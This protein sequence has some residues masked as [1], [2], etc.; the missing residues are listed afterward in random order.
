[1]SALFV[2]ALVAICAPYLQGGAT[3]ALDF[4]GAVLEVAQYGLWPASPIAALTI[5]TEIGGPFLILSGY[6]R[7]LG[8]FWLAAFT[9]AAT[10]AA[11]RFWDRKG[12]DRA[13]IENSFF[14]HFGLIGG[15]LLV[16]WY[17]LAHGQ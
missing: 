5:L 2:V 3:K 11:N 15:L 17:D 16:A 9:L 12:P 13:S 14:E 4:D 1:M 7:W 8:A 6:L 10:F